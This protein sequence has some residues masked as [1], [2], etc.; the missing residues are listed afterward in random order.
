MIAGGGWEG[1]HC[2]PA[3]LAGETEEMTLYRSESFGPVTSIHPID[4]DEEGLRRAND[5]EYGLSSAIFTRDI[6]QALRFAR[7]IGDGMRHI[8][9]PTIHDEAHMPFGESSVGRE[10]ADPD[11]EEMT[12][13]KWVTVHP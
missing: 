6:D 1:A 4:S 11:T 9:G 7:N 2:P 8:N 13:L 12:E 3:R 10:G 5:T